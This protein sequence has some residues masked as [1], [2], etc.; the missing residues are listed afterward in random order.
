MSPCCIEVEMF[1]NN[2]GHPNKRLIYEFGVVIG[3]LEM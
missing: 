3:G 1:V 2:I